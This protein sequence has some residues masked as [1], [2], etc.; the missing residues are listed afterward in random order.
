[1][2]IY[3]FI[4]HRNQFAIKAKKH[5]NS[6]RVKEVIIIIIID[7]DDDDDDFAISSCDSTPVRLVSVHFGYE[8]DRFGSDWCCRGRVF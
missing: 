6:I 2:Y 1:M 7:D 4:I 5:V 3:D 8:S